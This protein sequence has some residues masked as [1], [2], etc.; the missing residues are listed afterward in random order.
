MARAGEQGPRCGAGPISSTDA[1]ILRALRRV[2]R[3]VLLNR[4][5]RH[6]GLGACA[7]L[8]TVLVLETARRLVGI[9]MP[10]S[11]VVG[12][13]ATLGFATWA[14]WDLARRRSLE[15]AAVIADRRGDLKDELK[16]AYWFVSRRERTEWIETQKERAARTARG[17]EPRQL[18]PAEMPRTTLAAVGLALLILGLSWIPGR[19][20]LAPSSLATDPGT[21]TTDQQQRLRDIQELF[22]QAGELDDDQPDSGLSQEV[23]ERLEEA[24]RGLDEG[25]VETGE[26]LAE[27]QRVENLLEEGRLETNALQQSLDDLARDLEGGGELGEMAEALRDRQLREAAEALRGL[28]ERLP[29]LDEAARQELADRLEQSTDVGDS[30][31]MEELTE[32]LQEAAESLSEEE[33]EASTEA[34]ERAAEALE[35][36]ARQQRARQAMN[37]AA[38][39]MRGLQQSLQRQSAEMQQDSR[40][41]LQGPSGQAQSMDAGALAVASEEV[42]WQEGGGGDG[43]PP[44][45]LQGGPTGHA[46]G[47]PQGGEQPLGEPTRLE[48]QLQMEV[49][50]RPG[51]EP[52]PL[53]E[54]LFQERS[55]RQEASVRYREVLSRGEYAEGSALQ[56]ERIPWRYRD[57][58]KLYFLAIRPREDD[59][60]G[61]R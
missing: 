59:D 41:S 58:V 57:L 12:L 7:I 3:R 44:R 39:Q 30:P 19:P 22:R 21:L 1:T 11:T 20:L 53:P 2:D 56:V 28:A 16:T 45:D 40:R 55:R 34:M 48:V 25:E 27:M 43:Q 14:V 10:S 4:A 49:V 52:P 35:R 24:M 31:E 26:A 47:D 32:A 29:D 8:G 46:S 13:A 9:S 18:V 6:L 61:N 54:N 33:L 51:P 5:L 50:D 42:E 60:D 15:L 38:Q 17:L 36:M 23:R 37:E